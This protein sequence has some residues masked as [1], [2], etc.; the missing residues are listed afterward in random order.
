[1][2]LKRCLPLI[3]AMILLSGCSLGGSSVDELTDTFRDKWDRLEQQQSKVAILAD[4]GDRAYRYEALTEGNEDTGRLTVTAPENIAGTGTAWQDGQTLLEYDGIWLETGTLS[5][6]GLSPADSLSVIF[7]ACRRGVVVEQGLTDWAEEEQ[8]LYLLTEN[9]RTNAEESRIALWSDPETGC[10]H[11]AEIYWG[12][13]RVIHITFSEMS[14][15]LA[16]E[17]TD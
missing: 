5:P 6:D 2:I 7:D 10:L 12:G 4:Y 13:E 15:T 3:T 16:E 9:P 14:L 8:A 1:M 17:E 11:Q